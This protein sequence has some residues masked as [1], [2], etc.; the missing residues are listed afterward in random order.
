MFFDTFYTSVKIN[1][2]FLQFFLWLTFKFPLAIAAPRNNTFSRTCA[3][4]RQNGVI[5]GF[6]FQTRVDIEF[7]VAE[8]YSVRNGDQRLKK[9]H[10]VSMLLFVWLHEFHTTEIRDL[11]YCDRLT[12]QE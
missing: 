4:G 12:G 7:L 9:M 6:A 1:S 2:K 8:K 10:T 3:W 5:W 11:M